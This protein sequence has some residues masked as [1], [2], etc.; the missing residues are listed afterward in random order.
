[1]RRYLRICAGVAAFAMLWTG[2]AN[3]DKTDNVF[4]YATTATLNSPD[5]YHNSLREG[6]LLLGQMIFD[7]LLYYDAT[8]QQ[9]KPLLAES[10]KWLDDKTVEFHLR[11]DVK[12]QDGSDFNADDVVY[13]FNFVNKPEAKAAVPPSVDWIESAE[14]ID[15]YTVRIHTTVVNPI[16][17][18]Y[19]SSTLHVLPENYY[20]PNGEEPEVGPNGKM[21][22]TGPYRLVEFV[23]GVSARLEPNPNYMADSPKGKPSFSAIEYKMLPDTATQIAEI[24]SGSLDWIWRLDHDSVQTLAKNPD[25]ETSFGE[26]IRVGFIRLDAIGRSGFKA[27]QDVRVRRA[28]AH[29]LNLEK[30]VPAIVGVNPIYTPCYPKQFGCV[31]DPSVAI[32]HEYD[33]EKAKAL[34]A[35]AGYPDGLD[36]LLTDSSEV[37]PDFGLAITADLAK[38]GIR[39]KIERLRFQEQYRRATEGELQAD[40]YDYGSY[41]IKDV[42]LIF[43]TF[44][45]ADDNPSDY[46]KDSEMSAWAKEMASTIDQ[47][48][49][50]DLAK[51][52]INRVTDQVYWVPVSSRP[53]GY[54]Y[55]KDLRFQAYFDENPRLYSLSWK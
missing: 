53:V 8:D 51:K 20:G 28:F 3:A 10:W 35:E 40:I 2:S 23:P 32:R 34:L 14:K 11:Q 37:P 30:I 47:E 31:D 42:Q 7:T 5:P 46:T 12:F 16:A 29:A 52:V 49:R 55:T 39:A 1:M 6:L 38:V 9:V 4:R 41:G 27:F 45:S 26:T 21:V 24:M 54:A 19:F 33:P 44:F 13:T 22:G 17:M 18:D 36:V 25:L 48:K 15:N 43:S 50:L